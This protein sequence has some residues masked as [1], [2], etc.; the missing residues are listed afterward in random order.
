MLAPVIFISLRGA[1]VV[2]AHALGASRLERPAAAI[3]IYSIIIFSG[4]FFPISQHNGIPAAVHRFSSP[5]AP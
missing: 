4:I 3:N 5:R 1:A 2:T